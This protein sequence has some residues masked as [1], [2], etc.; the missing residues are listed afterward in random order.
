MSEL[1]HLSSSI[2]HLL[3][4]R[5]PLHAWTAHRRL[6]PD[7]EPTFSDA[8]DLG[9]V[10]HELVL[11]GE[12]RMAVGQFDEYRTNEAKAWRDAVRAD[13]RIPVR[14]KDLERITAMFSR[15]TEQLAA[16]EV[17]PGLF[18]QPGVAEHT[19]I[20]RDG[21]ADC[22]A[23]LDW[24]HEDGT[25]DDL[26]TT[27]RSASPEAYARRLYDHGGDIQAAMYVR[28]V[29]QTMELRTE[30][31]FRW[32]VCETEPPFCVSVIQPGA[33]VIALGNA[34][35]DLALARWTLAM[36]S[37]EWPGYPAEVH[38]ATLPPWEESR[39]LERMEALS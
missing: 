37:G 21:D 6:N 38:T 29:Q 5:S 24:L 3:V 25:I 26:K 7:Y 30:P 14:P 15:V 4:T 20:W 9:N 33:D 32:I 1:P 18:S 16:F 8:F 12:Q 28:G 31:A 27:S 10:V 23:R 34:K 2:A 11:G 39:F 36:E 35:L 19:I 17:S 13:G 22:K